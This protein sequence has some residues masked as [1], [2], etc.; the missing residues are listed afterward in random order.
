MLADTS[1]PSCEFPLGPYRAGLYSLPVELLALVRRGGEQSGTSDP[2][3]LSSYRL[4]TLL[5]NK[6]RALLPELATQC[7]QSAACFYQELLESR[8]G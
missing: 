7:L 1:F 8:A 6:G 3:P 5:S 2:H 4:P